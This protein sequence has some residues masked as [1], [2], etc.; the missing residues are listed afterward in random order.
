M[1]RR[2]RGFFEDALMPRALADVARLKCV[3]VSRTSSTVF[4]LTDQLDN[5]V[6]TD[7]RWRRGTPFIFVRFIYFL[8]ILLHLASFI[9]AQSG[10]STATNTNRRR[11]YVPDYSS[12]L[13]INGHRSALATIFQTHSEHLGP[14]LNSQE[15]SFPAITLFPYVPFRR[16]TQHHGER[17]AVRSI[18][19][20]NIVKF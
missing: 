14:I 3:G 11:R 9:S 16:S 1:C 10:R 8:S 12:L 4:K 20:H 2:H 18:C 15:L 17:G 19:L 5:G 13:Q 7:S 6:E